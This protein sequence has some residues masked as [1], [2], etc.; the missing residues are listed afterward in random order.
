MNPSPYTH[1]YRLGALL[2]IGLVVFLI[3]KEQAI[4][5]SWDSEAWY[6]KDSLPLLQEQQPVF[7]N[8]ETCAGAGCHEDARYLIDDAQLEH[9]LRIRWL[10]WAT[11]KN[12]S[13]ESCHGPLADH[14]K[15]GFKIEKAVVS[16]NSDLCLRCHEPRLGREAIVPFQ[17][18]SKYHQYREVTRES[19]CVRCHN[20]HEPK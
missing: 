19:T 5:E 4:P 1:L 6:R 20:P 10:D 14:V 11:H 18:D 8:N 17:E 7:G 13:C 12:L 2:A 3:V 9:Q 15:D 16:R